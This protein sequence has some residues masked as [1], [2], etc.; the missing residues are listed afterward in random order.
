MMTMPDG[1]Q[2]SEDG[3][4][5]W[6]GSQW[7]PVG[8]Q[9]D[10]GTAAFD[11]DGTGVRID[12]ENSPVPSA[13][14]SL[15]AAFAVCNTGTAAGQCVVTVQ[16][17]GQDSVTWQSPWLEPGQCTA[18]DGDGYVHGIPGQSEGRHDFEAVADPPGQGGGRSGVNSVD[19]G[20]PE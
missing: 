7:Q 3:Q 15:K 8:G 20:P 4:W 19:V 1:A 6:D 10:A 2:L 9:G 13:G 11:F 18:P 12:P 16:V 17:D 5:W 14:E